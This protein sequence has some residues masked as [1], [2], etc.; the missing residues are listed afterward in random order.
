MNVGRVSV[1][2][3]DATL[4]DQLSRAV[5]VPPSQFEF[6]TSSAGECTGSASDGEEQTQTTF[7]KEAS[8][9]SGMQKRF[10]DTE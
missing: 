4:R 3:S 10:L 9:H 5:G 6:V 8:S 1:G 7:G 2:E